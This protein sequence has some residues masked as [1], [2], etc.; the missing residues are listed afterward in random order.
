MM[1]AD[2]PRM[3]LLSS[4]RALAALLVAV[5]ADVVQLPL[6]LGL[7]ASAL[8]GIGLAATVPIE[9]VDLAVDAVTAAV[10][11]GLLGFH[12]VLL[13]TAIVEAVPGIDLVPTWTGSVLYVLWRR[14]RETGGM[15]PPAPGRGEM[16]MT[17]RSGRA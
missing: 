14:R 12:W 10:T 2:P 4:P 13:P 17:D 8:S 16:D 7:V 3:S 5:V 9:V 1:Q 6:T 15:M 11:I